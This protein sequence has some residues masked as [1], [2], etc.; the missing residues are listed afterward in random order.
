VDCN[1]DIALDVYAS[2]S[3][4]EMSMKARCD[5]WGVS[6]VSS[7]VIIWGNVAVD[8]WSDDDVKVITALL[9]AGEGRMASSF[10]E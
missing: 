6:H 3:E 7:E 2:S 9:G 5:E 4:L 10:C 1:D 8:A